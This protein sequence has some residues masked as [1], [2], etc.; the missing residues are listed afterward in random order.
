VGRCYDSITGGAVNDAEVILNLIRQKRLSK[1]FKAQDIYHQGLGCLSDS[2]RV[3]AA[4]ELLQDYGWVVS[5]KE[6]GVVGRHSEFWM[7]HPKISLN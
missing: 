5:E 7:A 1:R 3:R 4:L 6:K 2:M